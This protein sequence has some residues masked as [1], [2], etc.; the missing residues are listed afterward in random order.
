MQKIIIVLMLSLGVIAKAQLRPYP[1]TVNASSKIKIIN[2]KDQSWQNVFKTSSE[3]FPNGFYNI[4]TFL[5]NDKNNASKLNNVSLAILKKQKQKTIMW[6]RLVL[7]NDFIPNTV[8][9]HL[10]P[11]KNIINQDDGFIVEYS[12]GKW[13][14]SIIDTRQLIVI[15]KSNDKNLKVWDINRFVAEFINYQTISLEILN[16]HNLENKQI[17]GKIL[18]KRL[19]KLTDNPLSWGSYSRYWLIPPIEWYK[20]KNTVVFLFN[21]YRNPVPSKSPIPLLRIIGGVSYTEKDPFQK[22]ETDKE[23]NL[24]EKYLKKINPN[25]KLKKESSISTP[26]P[27]IPEI[28]KLPRKMRRLGTGN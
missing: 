18:K 8:L 5:H 2:L 22:F 21:K 4:A 9:D 15:I 7:R 25:F 11:V 24:L 27:P 13:L 28:K 12:I 26:L 3:K 1:H 16:I 10:M 23:Y 19:Q 6:L 14:I 20:N 17:C